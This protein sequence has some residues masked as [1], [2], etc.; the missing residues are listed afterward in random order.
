MESSLI[1]GIWLVLIGRPSSFA[2]FSVVVCGPET[3]PSGSLFSYLCFK[4]VIFSYDGLLFS[5]LLDSFVRVFVLL[6]LVGVS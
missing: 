3:F 6:I 1:L 2:V 5:V 4:F